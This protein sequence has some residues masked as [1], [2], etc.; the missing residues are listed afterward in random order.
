LLHEGRE[1]DG[2]LFHANEPASERQLEYYR[3][4]GKKIT[5]EIER[6]SYNEMSALIGKAKA[7]GA[8]ASY[9]I[10]DREKPATSSQFATLLQYGIKVTPEI[11]KMNKAEIKHIIAEALVQL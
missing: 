8:I 4:L 7:A 9:D 2:K 11:E 3:A 10:I 1:V 5:P 6:L